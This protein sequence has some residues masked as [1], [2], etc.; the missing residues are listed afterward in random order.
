MTERERPSAH[1]AV[2]VKSGTSGAI[3]VRNEKGEISMQKVK[4]QRYVAGKRPKYAPASSDNEEEYGSTAAADASDDERDE[5]D[6][7]D[8]DESA[9]RYAARQQQ[10]QQQTIDCKHWS[11][12]FFHVAFASDIVNMSLVCHSLSPSGRST[13]EESPRR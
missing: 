7:D 3:P 8:D 2:P 4:V 5:S 6:E 1:H 10:Q 11:V 12:F 13:P 9:R